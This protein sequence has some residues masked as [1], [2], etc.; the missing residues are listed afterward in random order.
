MGRKSNQQN[1][2]RVLWVIHQHDNQIRAADIARETGLHPEAV[3]RLLASMEK[4]T[5]TYLQ[6]DDKG[7][8]GIFKEQ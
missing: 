4:I 2:Y 8:L 1:A 6:E 5:G 3:S 7:N